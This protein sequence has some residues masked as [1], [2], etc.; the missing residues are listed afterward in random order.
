ME[1]GDRGDCQEETT[2]AELLE[3]GRRSRTARSVH[4][5]E[6]EADQ[7]A[8]CQARGR[9]NAGPRVILD[10]DRYNAARLGPSLPHRQG[11][12]ATQSHHARHAQ[13]DDGRQGR[14]ITKPN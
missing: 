1:E 7:S 4:A 6:R 8:A 13:S 2:E 11:C 10:R 5:I 9:G 14:A 3:Q 12:A